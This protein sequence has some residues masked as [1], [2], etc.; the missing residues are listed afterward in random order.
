V[1]ILPQYLNF[2]SRI[3]QALLPPNGS[4]AG[5]KSDP[6]FR[7][8]ARKAH[9]FLLGIFDVEMVG[10]QNK[11]VDLRM[12]HPNLLSIWQMAMG[13]SPLPRKISRYREISG[14]W[15][16]IPFHGNIL[17][18]MHTHAYPTSPFFKLKSRNWDI[19][20]GLA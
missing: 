10:K 8:D 11:S 9:G 20:Q 17:V 14:R 2:W 6:L 5:K 3:I 4:K 7:C 1:P 15:M 13:Q 18:L 12:A 16:F 19:S